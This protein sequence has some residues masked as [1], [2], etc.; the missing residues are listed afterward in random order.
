VCC[1][2]GLMDLNRTFNG[3]ERSHI[4]SVLA[5]ECEARGTDATGISYNAGGRMRVYKRSAPARKMHFKVPDNATVIMGHT[6]LTTQGSEKKNYNNHPFLGNVD[7]MQIALAHNGVI[8]NDRELRKTLKPPDAKIETDS[9]VAL[10]RLEKK[11]ALAFDSLKYMAE[12]VEGSFSFTI[13]DSSN[14]IWF[15]KGDNPLCIYRFPKYNVLLYASTEE[16][17]EGVH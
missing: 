7:G 17:P 12:T 4:L 9:Y 13:I 2:F 16:I 5:S 14:S 8:R 1:L 15:V 10:Q 3:K 11:R 6:R